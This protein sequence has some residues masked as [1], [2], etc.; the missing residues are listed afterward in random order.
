[1][2]DKVANPDKLDVVQAIRLTA[3]AW[4]DDVKQ[5]TIANC[6]RHCR[7]RNVP[8]AKEEATAAEDVATEEDLMDQEV[9]KDLESQVTQFRYRNL[10]APRT[11]STIQMRRWSHIYQITPMRLMTRTTVKSFLLFQLRRRR[12]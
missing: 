9:I 6:F 5:V 1:M 11:L 10:W 12:G 3:P 4:K 8:D 7:I 2:E